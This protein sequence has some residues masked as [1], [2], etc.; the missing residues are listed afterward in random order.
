VRWGLVIGL[1]TGLLWCVDARAGTYD[2]YGCPI[3]E[4]DSSADARMDSGPVLTGGVD[5]RQLPV[6]RPPR[7][8][9]R[10]DRDTESACDQ[11]MGIQRSAGHEHRG[12]HDPSDQHGQR[13]AWE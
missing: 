7:R 8:R 6:G 4:W 3:A 9:P 12:V 2:V 1:L 11:R 10:R 5:Q 13:H